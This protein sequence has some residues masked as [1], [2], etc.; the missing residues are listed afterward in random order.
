MVFIIFSPDSRM[1]FSHP[2][3][4]EKFNEGFRIF[5]ASNQWILSAHAG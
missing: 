4:D 2:V 3:V 5:Y 1:P